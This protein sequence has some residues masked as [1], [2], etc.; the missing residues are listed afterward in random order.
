MKSNLIACAVFIVWMLSNNHLSADVNVLIIGSTKDASERFTSAQSKPFS[1]TEIGTHLKKILEQDGRGTVNVTIE[2]RYR[3]ASVSGFIFPYYSY[4]LSNWFYFNEPAG[5]DA[6]RWQN[7]RGEAGTVWD[8]IILTDDPYAMEYTPGMFAQG[9]AKI[10]EEVAKSANPAEIVLL[11]PWPG[12]GSLSSVN[13]YKEVVYRTGRSGGFKV[14]PA[15]LAWQACE[16]PAGATHPTTAGAYIAAASI[17]SSIY[18][19]SAAASSYVYNDSHANTSFTTYTNNNNATHYTGVFNFQNPYKMLYDKRRDV[20]YM[21]SGTSTETRME[22]TMRDAMAR[23]GVKNFN[24]NNTSRDKW[25]IP[26]AMYWT[27]DLTEGDPLSQLSFGFTYAHGAPHAE[28]HNHDDSMANSMLTSSTARNT[29]LRNF[30][31]QIHKRFPSEVPVPDGQHLNTLTDNAVG[32]FMYTLYSGRCPMDVEP[33]STAY[34]TTTSWHASKIGYETAWQL[35]RCQTR[36]PGFK[37][38]PSSA[39]RDII[40]AGKTETMS[41]QFILPPKANVTVNITNSNPSSGIVISPSTLTFTPANYSTPQPVTVTALTGLAADKVFNVVYNTVSTDEVYDGLNDSWQYTARTIL[42]FVS[43]TAASQ[44]SASESGTMTVTAQLSAA[45]SETVTV[46]YTVTGTATGAD[47]S[48]LSSPIMIPAGATTGSTTITVNPD[49]IREFG[50]ETVILTMG[51]P[52]NARLGGVTVHTATIQ[53]D[54]NVAPVVN[55]GPDQSLPIVMVPTL[56]TPAMIST[57]A[58]YDAANAST[59]TAS[60][61]EVSEWRDISG[62]GKHASRNSIMGPMTGTNMINGKNAIYFRVSQTNTM[63]TSLTQLTEASIYLVVDPDQISLTDRY[64]SPLGAATTPSSGGCFITLQD[65]T[66]RGAKH[67]VSY[68]NTLLSTYLNGTKQA[69][70]HGFNPCIL[71]HQGTS[72]SSENLAYTI[73]KPDMNIHQHAYEGLIGEIIICNA[74]HDAVTRLKI[75]GYLAHKWGLTARLPA[76]HPYKTAAPT[77]SALSAN[78][79][80]T[81]SDA[82]GDPMTTTWSF[83]SGP[84]TQATFGNASAVDTTATMYSPGAYTFRLTA[85]DTYGPVSDDVVIYVSSDPA[86][87]FVEWS[88]ASQ[89]SATESGTMTVTAKLSKTYS[90]AVTVPFTVSGTAAAADRTLATT[91]ITIAA[92]A[93][94]GTKTIT[95]TADTLDELNET[96]ILT[97]GTPTNALSGATLVHTATITDD[98]VSSPQVVSAG[99][100]QAVTL[101][102]G[103]QQ[104]TWTPK[105]MPTTTAWYDAADASTITAGGALVSQW[106]DKSGFGRHAVSVTSPRTASTTMNGRNVLNFNNSLMTVPYSAA[107]N[108]ANMGIYTVCRVSGN[109]N[110]LRTLINS[111]QDYTG[112]KFEATEANAWESVGGAHDLWLKLPGSNVTISETMM[113]GLTMDSGSLSFYQNS[114]AKGSKTGFAVN[115]SAD[116][117]IGSHGNTINPFY[118]DI[119]EI[120]MVGQTPSVADRQKVE[121]YLAHKWGYAASLPADHPHKAIAPIT[122]LVTVNLDGTLGDSNRDPLTTT[123]TLISGPT[124]KITITNP[125]TVDTTVTFDVAGTY[126]FRLTANDLYGT[127]SDEVVITVTSANE[128]PVALPQSVKLMKNTP[129]TIVLAGTDADNNPLTYSIFQQP[130]HGTLDISNL[131][132]VI[133]TPNLNYFGPDSFLFRAHDGLIH[134]PVAEVSITVQPLGLSSF[135]RIVGAKQIPSV[136][137]LGY[138]PNSVSG[139]VGGEADSGGKALSVIVQGHGLPILPPGAVIT[140]ATLN[141]EVA[142]SNLITNQKLDAYLIDTVNPDSTGTTF[143]YHGAVSTTAT[144]KYINVTSGIGAK[145]MALSTQAL[146]LLK[147]YYGGDHIPE[148]LEAFFRFNLNPA[149]TNNASEIRYTIGNGV[150]QNSLSIQYVFQNT[151]TYNGNGNT[152]GGVPVDSNLY[153]NGMTAT[154]LGNTGNLVRAGY[155]FSGWNTAADGSGI[156]RAA[157]STFTMG[158]ANVTLHA[159]WLSRYDEW[160]A[161]ANPGAGV[162]A[163]FNG[164]ANGDGIANGLGWL[165][166]GTN[167]QQNGN[168]LLPKAAESGG[169][170]TLSFKML[171]S[172]QRGT[173]V[174]ALQYSRD[175]GVSDPWTNHTITVPDVSGTVGGVN[176]VITPI[177]GTDHNQV[178]VTIP[179]SAA[180]GTGKVFARMSGMFSP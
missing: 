164:D 101:L 38:M 133:Y 81:V 51:T 17:Y 8:Y 111:T 69:S 94:T 30:W 71:S 93:T 139:T 20:C 148:R 145:Q 82:N 137:P 119:A 37:V 41:V 162:D 67:D 43:W 16:S 42:P 129:Q 14:A 135:D 95:I 25:P 53:D 10:A 169:N 59:I 73:G 175:L 155:T 99:P 176:F 40:A 48:I 46:P 104:A 28:M 180:G 136:T 179:A 110:K 35:A 154:V 108:Q 26:Y 128:I 131:P 36:A 70:N 75:E 122:S 132:T 27:R 66:T 68:G 85:N 114:V 65:Y 124:D 6:T 97:M 96:V 92:G 86:I 33:N 152:G 153:D 143:Y 113:L 151:V 178:Q 174:L 63:M 105:F 24:A 147:S 158:A 7:L 52:T 159:K 170:L 62:N 115:T 19:Q 1:P 23:I 165:L 76:G 127:V 13:H 11:M 173:A 83:V 134:S 144:V 126:T 29:P 79:D 171:K 160:M 3:T 60:G 12:T 9:V 157:G 45:S 130:A 21:R 121:G 88:A 32:T 149:P 5:V 56:W 106:R 89:S 102:V 78:L 87:P 49:S 172:T 156:S 167:P 161:A 163:T 141:F 140:G 54:E 142:A 57:S 55:A 4:S 123:W 22:Y 100:D 146:D 120:V 47:Y 117:F 44:T 118:G 34:S 150:N 77:T 90:S 2:D 112:Y 74:D 80:G 138:Y 84:P 72:L 39:D 107:L 177:S 64:N 61:G 58:W 98:D 125:S 15:A 91:A 31:A 166:G 168:E 50:H 18:N 103:A 116:L 109:T